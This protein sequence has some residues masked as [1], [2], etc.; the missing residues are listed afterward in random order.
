M[1]T[2]W[3]LLAT[4]E[5]PAIEGKRRPGRDRE[6]TGRQKQTQRIEVRVKLVGSRLSRVEQCRSA[7][8]RE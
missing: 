2:S 5:M 7:I 4:L 1:E 3:T 8:L 6:G